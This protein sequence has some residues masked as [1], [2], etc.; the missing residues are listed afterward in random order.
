M[1]TTVPVPRPGILDI[2]PYIPGKSTFE[3]DDSPVIKLSSNESALGPSRHAVEAA[4]QVLDGIVRYPDGSATELRAAIAA[5]YG[6]DAT[7]IVCSN[8]SDE[9]LEML[10]QVYAGPGDEVVY[11]EYGFA[12]YPIA[13]MAAGATPVTAP[14]KDFR[15]DVDAM[16]DAVTDRTRIVFLANPNNPTG[17]YISKAEVQRLQDGLPEDVLFVI[18]AAYAEFVSKADFSACAELVPEYGNTVMTRTFSKIHSLAG[19]RVGWLYGPHNV[20]DALSRIRAPFNVNS[21]AQASA[22]AALNDREHV[23]KAREHNDRWLLRLTQ[24]LRG[25]GLIVHDSVVN[26]LLVRFPGGP[27]QAQCALQFLESHRILVRNLDAYGIPDGLRVNIGLDH[28]MEI[29]GERLA[30]F[31]GRA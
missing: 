16:L 25:M 9:V 24:T 8:G 20:V 30:E 23:V 11:S 28:E 10:P 5:H 12:I 14:E 2:K 13:T 17:S 29:L 15:V 7:R 6:L 21:V 18:D 4:R 19:L 27:E 22:V 3:G 31:M 1:K 26:F